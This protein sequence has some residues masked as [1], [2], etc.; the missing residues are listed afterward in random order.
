[1]NPPGF[2]SD[3]ERCCICGVD[4]SRRKRAWNRR[5]CIGRVDASNVQIEAV[6]DPA[7]RAGPC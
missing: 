6:R 1:M 7:Q 4:L 5:K 3:M 2:F